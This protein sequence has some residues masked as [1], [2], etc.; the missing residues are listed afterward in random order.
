MHKIA[1]YDTKIYDKESF[2]NIAHA[3][4][5]LK[6]LENKLNQ[7]TV[8]LAEGCDGV[9]AFVNDLIDRTTIEHLAGMGVGLIAM[10]CSGF[11][12]VD[13]QAASENKVTVVR[14]PG[15]SP[16]AVAEH[17]MGLILCLNRKIHKAYFRTRDFNFALNGLTGFDLHGKTVGIIGTGKIGKIFAGI[18]EGFGMNVIAYDL[19]PDK[20]SGINYVTREELFK[21][22]DI[23][24]LHCP[25]T[26]ETKHIINSET[27]RIMKKGVFIINTSR[28]ALVESESLYNAIRDGR[29]GA[30]GLDVYEEESDLFFEDCSNMII[31]DDILKL[32]LSLPNVLVTS[33]QAFLTKEALNNIAECTINNINAYFNGDKLENEITA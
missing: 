10:R 30:A 3:D 32:F 28:G 7:D 33:H 2:D 21:E 9:C 12:N 17:A 25:L 29:V 16:Y 22:S 23:I 20:E 19:Y 5:S 6:Y 4:I 24:S 18:C 14:V 15:Y 27:I 13:L 31:R 26:D 1:F 8:R 11:N